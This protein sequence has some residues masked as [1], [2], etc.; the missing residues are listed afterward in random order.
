MKFIKIESIMPSGFLIICRMYPYFSFPEETWIWS[1]LEPKLPFTEEDALIK[2]RGIAGNEWPDYNDSSK[3]NNSFLKKLNIEYSRLASLEQFKEINEYYKTIS[4]KYLC[5]FIYIQP[6]LA[7]SCPPLLPSCFSFYG[8]E[9]VDYDPS[10]LPFS[11]IHHQIIYSDHEEMRSFSKILNNN[12]LFNKLEDI[13]LVE[14]KRK[15]LSEN[16]ELELMEGVNPARIAIY[17]IKRTHT[18]KHYRKLLRKDFQKRYKQ[19][20]I[21]WKKRGFI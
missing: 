11:I 19:S 6:V 12:L 16:G 14:Q 15:E 4:N 1:A 17:A 18:I 9:Y 21:Y 10:T 7:N 2:Y 5:D 3:I 13:E 8:Y 20:I